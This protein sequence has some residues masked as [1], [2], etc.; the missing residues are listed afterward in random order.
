MHRPA[1]RVLHRVLAARGRWRYLG[2]LPWRGH[3]A[4]WWRQFVGA[5]DGLSSER[6]YTL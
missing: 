6:A 2:A 3:L 4:R 1:A 5:R